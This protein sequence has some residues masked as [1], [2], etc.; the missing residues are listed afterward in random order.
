MCKIKFFY[1][2]NEKLILTKYNINTD[3]GVD[4]EKNEWK[5][6]LRRGVSEL[7]LLCCD[8]CHRFLFFR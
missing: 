1:V 5:V 6:G 7:L 8:D 3:T 4:I 2:V